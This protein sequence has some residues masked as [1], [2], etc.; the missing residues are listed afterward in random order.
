MKTWKNWMENNKLKKIE[1]RNLNEKWKI[2]ILL[3]VNKARR[4]NV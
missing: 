2:Y 4:K 1:R 3:K